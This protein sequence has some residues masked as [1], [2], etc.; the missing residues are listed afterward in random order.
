MAASRFLVRLWVPG[1]GGDRSSDPMCPA[2]PG[3]WLART[4]HPPDRTWPTVPGAGTPKTGSDPVRR[5][6][7]LPIGV[8]K[9]G[10]P[11]PRPAA[12]QPAGGSQ[13]GRLLPTPQAATP[14]RCGQVAGLAR[15]GRVLFGLV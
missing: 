5:A 13:P 1:G 3:T 7:R 10:E 8:G 4:S 11:S 2:A 15:L 6:A 9:S 12:G 14:A